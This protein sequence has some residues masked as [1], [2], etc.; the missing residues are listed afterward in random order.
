MFFSMATL[1]EGQQRMEMELA[2]ARYCRLLS[3]VTFRCLIM[4]DRALALKSN[5]IV[6]TQLQQREGRES[7]IYRRT[8]FRG[9]QGLSTYNPLELLLHS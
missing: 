3:S 7:C 9:T 2:K 4:F 8:F 5:E 1:Q 6:N